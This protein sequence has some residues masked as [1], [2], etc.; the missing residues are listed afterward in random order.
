MN[1]THFGDI[2]FQNIYERKRFLLSSERKRRKSD[3]GRVI[4][5]T[6]EGTSSEVLP[7]DSLNN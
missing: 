1:K 5:Y 7:K 6:Q 3:L 2:C 4:S